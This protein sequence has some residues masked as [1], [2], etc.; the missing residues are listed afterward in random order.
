MQQTIHPLDGEHFH[1]GAFKGYVFR[2][3]DCRE[4][5]LISFSPVGDDH[6]NLLWLGGRFESPSF[7]SVSPIEI[8]GRAEIEIEIESIE[9]A[10]EERNALLGICWQWEIW[11]PIAIKGT[12]AIDSLERMIELP[13]E[14]ILDWFRVA[15]RNPSILEDIVKTLEENEYGVDVAGPE[16]FGRFYDYRRI[17]SMFRKDNPQQGHVV[18]VYEHDTGIFDASGVFKK[19]GDIIW[20][21]ALGYNRG[22]V[23]KIEKKLP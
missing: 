16:G 8:N 19:V 10:T 17:V 13:R 3:I 12:C 20:S 9:V 22:K 6:T 21:D 11:E 2:G 18:L 15:G 4:G 14:I 1:S 5:W 7:C 23:L